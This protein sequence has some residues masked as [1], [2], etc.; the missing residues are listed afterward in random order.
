MLITFPSMTFSLVLTILSMHMYII[1]INDSSYSIIKLVVVCKMLEHVVHGSL[2]FTYSVTR[3][4]IR[5]V[6]INRT[7][8]ATIDMKL[9]PYLVISTNI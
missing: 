8:H 3:M 7:H 6:A 9:Q 1:A 2:T 4:C 5:T